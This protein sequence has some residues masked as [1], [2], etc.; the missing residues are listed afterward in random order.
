MPTDPWALE[1]VSDLSEIIPPTVFEATP[2]T[3]IP[4]SPNSS[5]NDPYHNIERIAFTTY[6][7]LRVEF[8]D[9]YDISPPQ[10]QPQPGDLKQDIY[11]VHLAL[12]H[13]YPGETFGHAPTSP[14]PLR[15]PSIPRRYHI[16]P[17]WKTSFLWQDT[18]DLP[19]RLP[20]V[21]HIDEEDIQKWYP[22]L[23]EAFSLWRQRYE[24][25]F[26]KNEVHLG[27]GREV[28]EDVKERVRWYTEG[29]LLAG[30]LVLQGGG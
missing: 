26:E 30:W 12:Q 5:Q 17:E 23:V 20:D 22:V 27:S 15:D 1:L 10:P 4:P 16:F 19:N 29:F 18:I 11:R 28:F 14:P 21:Y 2:G 13:R 9:L 7:G 24:V 25:N 3:E 8:E 6:Y